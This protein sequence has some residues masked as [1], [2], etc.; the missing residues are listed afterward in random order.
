MELKGKALYNILKINASAHTDYGCEKW[1]MEDLRPVTTSLL[2][3]RLQD[4]K[5]SLD[6]KKFHLYT[7]ELDSP[8]DLIDCLWIDEENIEKRDQAYLILFELWRRLSPEK[9][10]LSILCDQLD[11]FIEKYDTET[12]QDEESLQ[13]ALCQLEDVLDDA[14]DQQKVTPQEVFQEVS[15]Y[16]AHDLENFIYDY[17]T[18]RI[19]EEEELYASE[20]IDAFYEFITDTKWFDFLRAQLF[21]STD[22]EKSNVL[23]E[24]LLEQLRDEPDVELLIQIIDCLI[25]FGDSRLFR[26]A[27]KQALALIKTEKEL[28]ELLLMIADYYRCLDREDEENKIHMLLKTRSKLHADAPLDLSDET[29]NQIWERL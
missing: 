3:K 13:E 22:S 8:E 19:E 14:C 18:A 17:I 6:E 25:H 26:L 10:S 23:I 29:L 27:I 7:Q 21:F 4:L 28:H 20:L 15:K 12:L 2:F 24:R 16:C 1:Q 5:I 11:H 9:Q